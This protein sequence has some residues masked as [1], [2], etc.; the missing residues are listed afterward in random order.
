[1]HHIWYLNGIS[2]IYKSMWPLLVPMENAK[3]IN[4]KTTIK[5]KT[6]KKYPKKC[7]KLSK[8]IYKKTERCLVIKCCSSFLHVHFCSCLLQLLLSLL[9]LLLLLLCCRLGIF[10]S[11]PQQ[12]LTD[13]YSIYI[14]IATINVYKI[15][16]N[17]NDTNNN[18]TTNWLKP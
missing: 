8:K 6:L 11:S 14:Y 15:K 18:E 12:Q 2:P 1:M 3:Q 5:K 4:G 10:L 17:N 16:L 9:S 13:Y 7:I